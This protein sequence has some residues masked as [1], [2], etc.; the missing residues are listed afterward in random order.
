[1]NACK[2][3]RRS[4]TWRLPAVRSSES[5]TQV[6]FA[7]VVGPQSELRSF[8]GPQHLAGSNGHGNGCLPVSN[9]GLAFYVRD[10]PRRRAGG[11]NDLR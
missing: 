2:L 8:A 7:Q 11:W 4:C 6:D 9:A 3:P 5:G 1:M 10:L